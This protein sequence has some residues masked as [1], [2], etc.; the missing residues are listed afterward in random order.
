MKNTVQLILLLTPII[1][2]LLSCT[3]ND[4]SKKG[5][6]GKDIRTKVDKQADILKSSIQEFNYILSIDHS[7]LAEEAGVYTPPSIVTLFSNSKVNSE[8]IRIN[9]M[10]GLDLPYKVLCYSEP[11]TANA[12]VAYTSPTFLQ[13]RHGLQDNDL[14]EFENDMKNALTNF[15]ETRI[16]STSFEKVKLN[17]GIIQLKSDYDFE[18]TIQ[19]LKKVIK[20]QNDTKWFGEINF[21]KEANELNIE[22][23]KTTLLLFGGP[24]P[25]GQAMFDCPRLGLDAFCQKL[26]VFENNKKQVIVAL[27]DI[28]A[29]AELYYNRSTK[30]QE[31]INNRLKITFETAITNKN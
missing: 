18:T 6:E 1:F 7:R 9:P 4:K 30:P 2:I 19:Q 25:G 3:S 11:D 20:A 21:Q 28:P 17:Y 15:S 23:H 5:G 13:K 24:A 12:V 14:R 8:L 31:I 16:I 27:N 29:F 26:L 22:I 10:T